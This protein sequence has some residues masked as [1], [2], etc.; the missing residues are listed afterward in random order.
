MTT[1]NTL[2]SLEQSTRTIQNVKRH[3]KQRGTKLKEMIKEDEEGGPWMKGFTREDISCPVCSTVVRGDQDVLDAHVDAC[4][5]HE[6]QRLEET[7]QRELQHR[8]AI[9]E[10]IWEGSEDGNGGTY[11]GNIRGKFLVVQFQHVLKNL[12]EGAGFYTRDDGKGVDDEIDI[13]GDDQ[14]AFGDAQFTEGDIVPINAERE[15]VDEDVEVEIMG[16]N[17]DEAQLE[18]MTLRDLIVSG[19]TAKHPALGKG[20]ASQMDV[21]DIA[22]AEKLD[23]AILLARE[24][25]DKTVLMNALE[26]KLKYMVRNDNLTLGIELLKGFH[27]ESAPVASSAPLL[28]RICID[29]YTEP[30]VSTG[31]WHTCCKECWLRCL[32]STKLC[33]ICKRI[34]GAGDLRRVYL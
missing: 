33:P 2:D 14:I 12:D 9:E 27:Q 30:T 32:G 1:R 4:L 22:E 5:A 17:D 13:D 20:E 28:C 25:G 15:A 34:T 19:K 31:C 6:M 24:R 18:Q 11:V 16:D 23:L 29:P 10:G 8:R 21:M 3:R 26:K 7:R